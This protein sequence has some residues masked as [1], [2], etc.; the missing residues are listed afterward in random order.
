[1]TH[2]RPPKTLGGGWLNRSLGRWAAW[3]QRVLLLMALGLLAWPAQAALQIEH[4]TQD[5][6]VRV[7]LVRSDVLPMLDVQVDVDGGGRRDPAAQAGLAQATALM[8]DKGVPAAGPEA[9]ALDEN[10]LTEA[11][12]DLGA[13]FNASAG[14]DRLSVH[15]RT[16]V[17]PEVLR[18]A[19][20]LA[21]RVL[22]SPGF[23]EPVWERERARLVSAWREA[24]TRPDVRAEQLFSRAVYGE[25]PYGQEARPETW[26][27]I[28]SQALRGFYRRH[29]RACDARVTLVG[30]IDRAAAEP[31]VRQLLAGWA[32]HGCDA[33]PVLPEVPVTTA[34]VALVEP[35]P[36][37]QAQVLVGQRGVARSDP[38]FLALSVGNHI[39][40]GGGFT[41]RLMHTLREQRG[42]TYGVYSSF[43]PGRHAGAFTASLQTRPDQAGQALVLLQQELERFT[44]EGPTQAELDRAKA[45]LING[46]SL[47]L[48][49]NRKWLEQVSAMAWNDLP[50]DHLER[51]RERVA[52][53]DRAQVLRAWQRVLHPDHWVSVVV[54]G[55]P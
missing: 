37:A 35:F 28:D 43:A 20:A 7:Y 39:L 29:A 42:L 48:D 13:A 24:Q 21:A 1:M 3:V 34:A 22:A 8:L 50:L 12:V 51:W 15:V 53:V 19:V 18:P 30:R 17:E 25:H 38:D 23:P 5:G 52:A 16:L 31:L 54:G 33:L 4:W 14:S 49:S 11:W 46:F 10:A 2:G 36:A 6:G 40:G 41:S 44:R 45:S 26:A 27:A 47:R 9:L 32:A 55:R